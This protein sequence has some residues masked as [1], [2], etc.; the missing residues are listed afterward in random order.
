MVRPPARFLR[1]FTLEGGHPCSA[2]AIGLCHTAKA[3]CSCPGWVQ[4]HPRFLGSSVGLV[5][6]ASLQGSQVWSSPHC[7]LL[8]S[9]GRAGKDW[10]Q[11]F[12]PCFLLQKLGMSS[13][14]WGPGFQVCT[15][16]SG[17]RLDGLSKAPQPPP[18]HNPRL[19]FSETFGARPP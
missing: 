14:L 5:L 15:G 6:E 13:S 12:T 18:Q 1:T 8:A 19:S 11:H 7:H 16:R 9:A 3:W 17:W 2:T 4:T 10:I